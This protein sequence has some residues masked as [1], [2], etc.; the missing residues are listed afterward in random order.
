MEAAE[1][2]IAA[3]E[4]A[5]KSILDKITDL[6]NAKDKKT[7]EDSPTMKGLDEIAKGL[8]PKI[9]P[10]AAAEAAK[11]SPIQPDMQAAAGMQAAQALMA[12]IMASKKRMGT[13]LTGRPFG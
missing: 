7:G 1:P 6:V 9:N 3:P 5:Q 10:A 2:A 4:V 13:T 8:T 12:Q 11:I